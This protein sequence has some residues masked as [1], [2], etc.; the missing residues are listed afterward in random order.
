M[1][2]LAQQVADRLKAERFVE[3]EASGRHV[4]L[5]E[6]DALTLF[7]HPMTPARPLSQPG[8]F[9]CAERVTLSGPKGQLARVAVLGP[10][11]PASQVEI[12]QTDALLLGVPA[13]IRLSGDIAGSPGITIQGPCGEV[14]LSEGVI[15]AQRHIHMTEQDARRFHLSN[16]QSVRVKLFSD[17]PVTFE[18]VAV[19][20]SDSFATRVHIDFDE[21]N[22]VHF[23]KGNL[24]M[25][26]T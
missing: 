12:S 11:R 18:D 7:G 19:R 15:I 10:A 20:V 22:A 9:A 13:P 5:T 3:V 25:I 6:Q 1:D 14:R 24:G 8:Q 4:H 23:Q 17:R 16:G 21:A 2:E 26:L